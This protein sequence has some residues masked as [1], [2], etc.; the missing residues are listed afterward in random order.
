MGEGKGV[1]ILPQSITVQ[2]CQWNDTPGR[3]QC[4]KINHVG[5]SILW[6]MA[7]ESVV[8][9]IFLKPVQPPDTRYVVKTKG[10]TAVVDPQLI[11]QSGVWQMMGAQSNLPS[12]FKCELYS[13]P[14][15][16]L[17]PSCLPP[18]KT[19]L[20]WCLLDCRGIGTQS[21]NPTHSGQ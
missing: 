6:S 3:S 14:P 10:E 2:H 8:Q 13:H 18:S 20:I 5:E 1:C 11:V 7:A 19:S 15:V 16:M 4:S 9:F 12:L 17:E 21:K